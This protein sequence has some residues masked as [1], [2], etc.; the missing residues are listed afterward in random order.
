MFGKK[1]PSFDEQMVVFDIETTG[2]SNRS[3]KIIEIGAVKIKDGKILDTMDIFIDPEC[4]IPEEITKLT[5]ITNDMVKG[6][7][8]EKEGLEQFLEFASDCLLIAHNAN[9]DIGFIRVAA[10]RNNLPFEN[11]YLDTLGLSRYVNSE[12]KNHKLDTIASHYKLADFNHHRASDDA[13][14]LAEIFFVMLERL[15]SEGIHSFEAVIE[16]M[17]EKTDPLKLPYY[18]MVIFAKNKAGLK[19]LYKL[20]SYSYLNYYKRFPR[21]P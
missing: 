14:I 15:K 10:E 19:N 12:L 9:F 13:K 4:E 21:I 17:S 1:Y 16:V 7:P 3:C 11:S 6:A 20:I 5:S 2:L 8:K 18:H